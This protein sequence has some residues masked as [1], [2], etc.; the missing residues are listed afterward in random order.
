MVSEW[1]VEPVRYEE[2]D[3]TAPEDHVE[4][5]R[6]THALGSEGKSRVGPG[7]AGLGEQPIAK[8]GTRSG[9][10]RGDVAQG[11]GGEV[12]AKQSATTRAAR[13]QNGVGQLGVGN[14]GANFEQRSEQ[15]VTDVD[16]GEGRDL[17]AVAGHKGQGNIE[18]KEKGQHRSNAD[19]DLASGEG[20]TMPPTAWT[21]NA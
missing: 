21:N 11:K 18:K 20:P 16:V 5:H 7:D 6:R 2:S 14:Q 19:P 17:G 1:R 9:S 13:R 4:H 12:D 10:A 8:G 3:E 15:Q